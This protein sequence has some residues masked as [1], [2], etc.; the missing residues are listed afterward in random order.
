[1]EI[2]IQYWDLILLSVGVLLF[3]GLW[4]YKFATT[5]SDE[6][7]EK[8]KQW[9]IY[10][11][12]EAETLM[13]SKTGQLKMRYVYDKFNERFKWLSFVLTFEKFNELLEHALDE[14]KHLIETNPK[15][16]ELVKKEV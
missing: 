2:L 13:K 12:I 9:L 15:I 10:A 14:A 11:C 8:V 5:P 3:V 7:L 1:M 4:I 6:Q 16:K